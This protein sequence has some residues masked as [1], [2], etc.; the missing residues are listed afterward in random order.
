MYYLIVLIL[1]FSAVSF[2]LV[3]PQAANSIFVALFFLFLI[4]ALLKISGLDQTG[5]V[6]D[7]SVV[8]ALGFAGLAVLSLFWS[9]NKSLSQH[10]VIFLLANVGLYL[11]VSNLQVPRKAVYAGLGILIVLGISL[12]VYGLVQRFSEVPKVLNQVKTYYK[13]SLTS[14]YINRNH[15]AG[16]L[17]MIIPLSLGTF[18]A[19]RK[20][21]ALLFS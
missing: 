15:F 13:D 5:F 18:F 10:F 19:I 8:P 7:R 11:T 20:K 1:C 21:K 4:V 12:C 9:P 14:T 2:G 17:E 16:L 6:R 3:Q